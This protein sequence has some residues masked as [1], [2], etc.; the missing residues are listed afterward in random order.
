MQQNEIWASI[1]TAGP[2]EEWATFDP[3]LV[4]DVIGAERS[5]TQYDRRK[6]FVASFGW[7]VPTVEAIKRI[8]VSVGERTILEVCAGGGLW[9]SLLSEAGA[10]LIAT[11]GLRQTVDSHFPVEV[12]EAEIA[13]RRYAG[14]QALLLCWPPFRDD[15]AFRALGAFKGDRV[16]YVGDARFTA[17]SQFHAVLE[18]SWELTDQFPLPSWPGIADR[19]CI[20]SKKLASALSRAG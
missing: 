8:C 6:A 13:V 2:S 20:Y 5:A 4:D 14:C 11:D 9:A 17:D 18:A 12:M 19:A 3:L 7:S 1:A 15:C 10:T 16:V